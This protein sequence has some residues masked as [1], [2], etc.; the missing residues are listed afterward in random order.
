MDY[1]LFI[2]WS[3]VSGLT[4]TA[5]HAVFVLMGPYSLFWVQDYLFDNRTELLKFPL[6]A[7]AL[8]GLSFFILQFRILS[9]SEATDKKAHSRI[10]QHRGNSI[11]NFFPY[12]YPFLLR[13]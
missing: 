9:T 3:L 6:Y 11:G 7:L 13:Y 5:K 10:S 1:N 2:T 4:D 12:N 8:G